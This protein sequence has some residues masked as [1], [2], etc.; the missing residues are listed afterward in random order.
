MEGVPLTFP[1]I[2]AREPQRDSSCERCFPAEASVHNV[3]LNSH[4]CMSQPLLCTAI[5]L[6]PQP[7]AHVPA[8]LWSVP[9]PMRMHNS[10]NRGCPYSPDALILPGAVGEPSLPVPA[11]GKPPGKMPLPPGASSL[12]TAMALNSLKWTQ[13]SPG[14]CHL[15][16]IIKRI[17]SATLRAA[18]QSR[19]SVTGFGENPIYANTAEVEIWR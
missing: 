11:L 9:I 12:H 15:F 1:N 6:I 17:C 3:H 2:S 13:P 8:W 5:R 4:P 14:P 18:K 7:Q 10:Q 16:F 19:H